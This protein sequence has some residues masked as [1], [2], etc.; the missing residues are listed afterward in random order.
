MKFRVEVVCLSDAGQED[1]S[2][3]LEMERRQLARETLD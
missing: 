1:G 3:V 2:D